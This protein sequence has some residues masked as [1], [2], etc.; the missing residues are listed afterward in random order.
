M[1]R[2]MSGLILLAIVV[3]SGAS[4][5]ARVQESLQG[6]WRVVARTIPSSTNK[7]DRQDPFSH[8]PEGTQTNVQPGLLIF[9]QKYYSRTTDTAVAPRPTSSEAI[10]GKPTVE[11]L[12]AR[13]GPFQ[14][15]A[16][17]YELS[18]DILTLRVMVS[19]NPSDQRENFARLK[20]KLD[21]DRLALTPIENETGRIVAGVTSEYVRVE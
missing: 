13:W 3:T 17:T 2:A 7:G 16:G 21:G 8:V 5:P 12:Q 4:E 11:E 1:L 18:G 20:V 15:N 19:K 6:V 10:P 9:T 14:A